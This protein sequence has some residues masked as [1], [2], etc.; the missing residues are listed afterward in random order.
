MLDKIIKIIYRK[1]EQE[2]TG[3]IARLKKKVNELVDE[4]GDPKHVV[5]AILKRDLAWYDYKEATIDAQ[6]E[7]VARADSILKNATYQNEIAHVCADLI[8]HIAKNTENFEQ[9]RDARMTLNGIK[10][11]VDRL[12]ELGVDNLPT[13][14]KPFSAV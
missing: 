10:L 4:L 14:N 12:E 2:L 3:E 1:R 13:K 8:N 9:V 5:K 11:L 6:K 7:Y